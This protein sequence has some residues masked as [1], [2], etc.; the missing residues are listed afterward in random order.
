M[1]SIILSILLFG[2]SAYLT[3]YS[4]GGGSV[5][6]LVILFIVAFTGILIASIWFKGNFKEKLLKA[7]KIILPLTATMFLLG[8]FYETLKVML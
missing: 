5:I 3:T 1:K 7:S 6:V 2:F 4:S 8:Y